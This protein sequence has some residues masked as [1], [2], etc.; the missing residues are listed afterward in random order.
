MTTGE[1]AKVLGRD[2]KYL[3]NRARMHKLRK[4]G[5]GY[6][7]SEADVELFR[8]RARKPISAN[9]PSLACGGRA[10]EAAEIKAAPECEPEDNPEPESQIR[11][12]DEVERI[13]FTCIAR[14]SKMT[15]DRDKKRLS[16]VLW[17]RRRRKKSLKA[18]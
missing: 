5:Y 17:G 6:V 10:D 4:D 15:T 14:V 2:A 18:R 9:A 16:T 11:G 7:W 13:A 3:S 8:A 1:A 12:L